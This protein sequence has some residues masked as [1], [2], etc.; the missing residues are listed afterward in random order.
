MWHVGGEGVDILLK[1]Q[2]P[3]SN[4]LE[5]TVLWKYLIS[6]DEINSNLLLNPPSYQ[7]ISHWLNAMNEWITMV[8]VKQPRLQQVCHI[9]QLYTK[10]ADMAQTKAYS[11]N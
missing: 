7:R 2:L 5:E 8:F 10:R 6:Y 11:D 9:G 4:G 3:G 1:F